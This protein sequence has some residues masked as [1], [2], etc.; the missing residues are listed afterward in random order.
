[1]LPEAAQL[2]DNHREPG[3]ARPALQR[4]VKTLEFRVAMRTEL[5]PA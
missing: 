4:V 5:E 1:V 2:L 3:W